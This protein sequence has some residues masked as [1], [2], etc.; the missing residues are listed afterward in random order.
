LSVQKKIKTLNEKEL[1]TEANLTITTMLG[2]EKS[3]LKNLSFS[4]F[5]FT[6][7]RQSKLKQCYLVN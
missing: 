5:I 1:I 3:L 7:D 6:V 4:N 2:L